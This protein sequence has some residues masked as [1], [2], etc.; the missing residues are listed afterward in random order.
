MVLWPVVGVSVK[1]IAN[2]HLLHLFHLQKILQSG[3][4]Q[5]PPVSVV[6]SPGPSPTFAF[7]Y[8]LQIS[9][10]SIFQLLKFFNSRSKSTF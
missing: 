3:L 9:E 8:L 1:R 4:A 6:T 5:M 7:L 2:L 10:D